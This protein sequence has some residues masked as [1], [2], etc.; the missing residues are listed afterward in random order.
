[1][2]LK[3]IIDKLFAFGLISFVLFVIIQAVLMQNRRSLFKCDYSPAQ[4]DGAP[5]QET[6]S[7]YFLV[8][9]NAQ[10]VQI[11][12]LSKG[13]GVKI[14]Y[15]QFYDNNTARWSNYYNPKNS[16][17]EIK[18]MINYGSGEFKTSKSVTQQD[19][20]QIVLETIVQFEKVAL[21]S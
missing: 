17:D 16:R 18:F 8:D 5:D 1:M 15:T 19:G 6:N 13:S 21:D 4:S 11:Y 10:E 12:D 3:N 9:L 7:G 14:E 2:N 20:K